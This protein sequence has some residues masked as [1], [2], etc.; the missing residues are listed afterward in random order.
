MKKIILNETD[1]LYS[2]PIIKLPGNDTRY[3]SDLDV[4]RLVWGIQQARQILSSPPLSLNLTIDEVS[5]GPSLENNNTMLRT[6]VEETVYIYSHWVGTAQM[7][8][9]LSGNDKED[10]LNSVVDPNLRVRGTSNLFVADASVMPFIPNGNVHS[11]V[12]M[13]GYRAADLIANATSQK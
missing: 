5:P 9:S 3:L 8:D 11:T 7:G 4:T 10:I 6:W 12:A 1:P 13:V 2:P